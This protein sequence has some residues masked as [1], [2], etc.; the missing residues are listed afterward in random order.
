MFTRILRSSLTFVAEQPVLV[1]IAFLTGFVETLRSFW[2]FG[3]TCYIVLKNNIDIS[4]LEGSLGEYLRAIFDILRQNMSFGSL[5]ALV[6]S[7]VIGYLFLHPIGHGMMVAYAQYGSV[8]KAFSVSWKR[9]FTITIA[10]TAISFI[11]LGS[12]HLMILRSF[13]DWGI[14]DNILIQ[15]FLLFATAFLLVTTFVYSYVN[16]SSV[17]DDFASSRPVVQ[18]QESL[19]HS[20]KVATDH[21][22]VTLKF[23]ILS[24]VL[25]IRF[26]ITS[27]FVIGVPAIF[28]WMLMQVGLINA[29]GAIFL[30]MACAGVLLLA[31]VY[32]NSVIDAFF[33]VFWTKTYLELKEKQE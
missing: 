24:L 3:Y 25:Q 4:S 20:F 10:Q 6:L 19:K 28:I 23:L 2:R 22:F 30:V 16:I 7:L 14:L 33:A 15:I 13:Y 12:W 27:A 32:I 1:R 18:A 31:S 26:F 8:S 29:K 5:V 17:T 9:Y 21:P 11:T